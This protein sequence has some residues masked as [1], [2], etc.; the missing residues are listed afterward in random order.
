[1]TTK[2]QADQVSGATPIDPSVAGCVLLLDAGNITAVDG[3]AIGTWADAS[4][5]G[6]D[7]T[8]A[9]A[10]LKPT[11]RENVFNGKPALWFGNA[12]VMDL[13]TH[14]NLTASTIFI[15]FNSL[16]KTGFGTLLLSEQYGFYAQILGRSN[17]GIYT[18]TSAS[19]DGGTS[20]GSNPIIAGVAHTATSDFATYHNGQKI[21]HVK[22][23][24]SQYGATSKVGYDGSNYH[25]G[26]IAEIRVFNTVLSDVNRKLYEEYFSLKYGI[27]L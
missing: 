20:Q 2:I 3:D 27:G 19:G 9:T 11:Y 15:V 22:N 18:S 24:S 4:A 25:Y 12:N 17:W 8:Q 13:A 5:S 6:N 26:F 1:M 21:V 14:I 16:Y 7:A 10:G 23:A